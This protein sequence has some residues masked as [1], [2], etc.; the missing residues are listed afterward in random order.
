MSMQ[1]I[2]V[3][4][5][6]GS[7]K[8]TFAVQLS[9]QLDLPVIHLDKLNWIDDKNTLNPAGFDELLEKVLKKDSWIID[10]N[11]SRTLSKRLDY[12]DTVIWLDL[13]KTICIYR[14]WKRYI[15]GKMTKSRTYGNPIKLEPGFVKFVWNFNHTNRPIILKILNENKH[16]KVIILKN[17]FEIEEIKKQF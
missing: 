3:I 14:I 16:K 8:S 2:L 9:K 12:A 5:S 7:G 13:P 6:P 1:K 17:Q 4:G 15:K 11:Y 10:G